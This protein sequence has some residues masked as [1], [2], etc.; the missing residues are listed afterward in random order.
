[1][2]KTKRAHYALE[3]KRGQRGISTPAE[4]QG[5][6]AAS[7]PG[8]RRWTK[9]SIGS[10]LTTRIGYTRLSI[11]SAHDFR[12]EL[13]RPSAK[14]GRTIPSVVGFVKQG[15]GQF[16]SGIARERVLTVRFAPRVRAQKW[17]CRRRLSG[18][19]KRWWAFEFL[20]FSPLRHWHQPAF[21]LVSCSGAVLTI[22]H[23]IIH[24][25]LRI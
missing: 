7:R 2:S 4:R 17:F 3:F 6:P 15:Q 22:I 11:T 5:S 16:M 20:L 8:A 21:Y 13:A 9:W 1:M 23:P 14:C 10:T 12:E 25:L 19:R 24:M 18:S